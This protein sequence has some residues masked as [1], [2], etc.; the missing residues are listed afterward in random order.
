[1]TIKLSEIKNKCSVLTNEKGEITI[2]VNNLLGYIK[3]GWKWKYTNRK[4]YYKGEEVIIDV[5]KSNIQKIVYC[6]DCGYYKLS[7]K[8]NEE[9][10]EVCPKCGGEYCFGFEDYKIKGEDFPMFPDEVWE[11]DLEEEDREIYRKNLKY[12]TKEGK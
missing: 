3:E 8:K 6:A 4:F 1:M 2:R 10:L 7:K 9:L 5:E 12:F 11:N